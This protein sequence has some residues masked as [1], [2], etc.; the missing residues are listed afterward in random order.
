VPYAGVQAVAAILLMFVYYNANGRL[1]SSINQRYPYNIVHNLLEYQEQHIQLSAERETVPYSAEEVPEQLD[2]VFILGEAVR[3]DHMQLNG[4]PR[5]TTPRLAARRN[6]V[7]LPNIYSEHTYTSTS[8][9]HILSP[10]DS[11]H[12]EMCGTHSSFIRT[13]KECGFY[14][15]WISNQDNG[16]TYVSFIHESDT[17]IFPNASKSV[18]VFEPWYDEQLLPAM[19]TL[20]QSSGPRNLYTLHSIGS[21]WYYNLHVPEKE[22]FF[23]PLTTDRVITNNTD[24]QIINSYDNTVRY[25]DLVADSIIQRFENRCAIVFYLSDH[26]EALGENGIYLH[27]AECDALHRPACFIWYSDSYARLY[28]EK[29]EALIFHKDKRYRTDFVYYS[30]LSAAGI[31]A[32]GAHEMDIFS[33]ETDD[34]R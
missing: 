14:T 29:I 15:A 17:I 7:S 32:E 30:I 25:M 21:H 11:I 8:V 20:L 34:I 26:G 24:E 5:E 12:T 31:A 28:P 33:F 6:I 18:F 19:D 10:A 3:A 4:Y 23:Q 27:A 22:L 16:H 2:V 9:P 13:M 1:R